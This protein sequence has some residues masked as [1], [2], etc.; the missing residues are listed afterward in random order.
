MF[1]RLLK[2][3]FGFV[4]WSVLLLVVSVASAALVIGFV[5]KGGGT[6]KVPNVMGLDFTEAS[7]VM[8]EA[9]L[10]LKPNGF[11]YSSIVPRNHVVSQDPDPRTVRKRSRSVYVVLSKGSKSVEAPKLVGQDFRQARITANNAEFQIGHLS[12]AHYPTARDLVLAQDPK[13]GANVER[14]TPVNLLLSLGPAPKRYIMPSLVGLPVAEADSLLDQMAL[15]AEVDTKL[16]I[17]VPIDMVVSQDPPPWSLIIEGDPI[18]LTR[19]VHDRKAAAPTPKWAVIEV[20][21]EPGMSE[22]L[23]LHP[24]S[25]VLEMIELPVEP[26]I[27][28]RRVTIEMTDATGNWTVFGA[29]G[30]GNVQPGT[31][32][33]V[34]VKYYG[35]MR[36]KVYIDDVLVK[37]KEYP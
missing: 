35:T 36:A 13:P 25:Q 29:E 21:V 2:F 16:D 15:R 20:A 23:A 22:H 7:A 9:G 12:Y 10:S 33:N 1:K 3:I 31:T 37:E 28:E 14:D 18:N 5:V 30:E 11:T 17:A 34:P 19:S 24:G 4:F 27:R 6:V 26:E 8:Q 32:I